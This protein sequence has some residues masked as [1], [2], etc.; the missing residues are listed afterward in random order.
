MWTGSWIRATPVLQG[1]IQAGFSIL[2]V[3]SAFTWASSPQVILWALRL[4]KASPPVDPGRSKTRN[5]FLLVPSTPL[6]KPSL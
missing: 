6:V 5:L 3:A 1:W 4:G 2:Q